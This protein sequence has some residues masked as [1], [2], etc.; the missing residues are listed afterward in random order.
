MRE[1]DE[2]AMP[3][4]ERRTTA[5]PGAV[6]L[7]L[8]RV[9]RREEGAAEKLWR[10]VY[11]ELR[12]I[13]R[14]QMARERP[15][16]T[17]QPTAL[18]HEA[19]L[20]LLGDTGPV[21]KDRRYFF[22]AAADAMRRILIDRARRAAR[23]KRGGAFQRVELDENEPA[24]TPSATELLALDEALDGLARRDESMAQV[25]KL[26]YF[27]GLSVEETATVLSVS[28]RTVV[29]QWRAARAWLE[30]RM[31]ETGS[32]SGSKPPDA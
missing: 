1:P 30:R 17:L 7:L 21:S 23:Q 25:V 27:A 19:Y 2:L 11:G 6:T 5:Q 28:E 32:G 26:R 20:R 29:R 22:A 3:A 31:S 24:I 13:A 10:A 8:E 9:S 4:F 15:G 16:A 18:I 12:R 14:A